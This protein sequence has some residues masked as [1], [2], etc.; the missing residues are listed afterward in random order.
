MRL[1]LHSVLYS[2]L[3]GG[4]VTLVLLLV[5]LLLNARIALVPKQNT[6]PYF[7]LIF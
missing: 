1:K 4:L 6:Q 5:V 7:K 2:Q 3:E